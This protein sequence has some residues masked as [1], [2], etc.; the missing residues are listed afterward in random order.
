MTRGPADPTAVAEFHNEAGGYEAELP[1]AWLE[2]LVADDVVELAGVVILAGGR[3]RHLDTCP[4]V[5]TICKVERVTNLAQ[6]ED[7][8]GCVPTTSGLAFREHHADTTLGG[9]PARI[10]SVNLPRKLLAGPPA[11]YC[12]Y[13]MHARRPYVLAFDYWSIRYRPFFAEQV[14]KIIASFRFLD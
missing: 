8:V 9:E 13:A 3:D 4:I 6:L 11:W 10:E 5:G 7:A 1:A 2:G 12:V 14:D